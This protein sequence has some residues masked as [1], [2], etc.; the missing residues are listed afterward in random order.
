MKILR[1]TTIVLLS[2]IFHFS[3]SNDI[4]AQQQEGQ[5]QIR[6]DYS[7]KELQTFVDAN[8]EVAQ[9]QNAAEQEMISAIEEHKLDVKVFNEILMAKQNPNAEPEA[10]EEQLT[11]FDQA[12]GDVM[13]I[14]QKTENKMQKA[15]QDAG[16][17]VEE[18]QQIMMAYQQSPEV[19]QK[20]NEL[21]G[22]VNQGN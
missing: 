18:Y 11:K 5:Q 16:M 9:I 4:I 22:K 20:V 1:K 15:I 7:E 10:S 6:E 21:I 2:V 12:I 17:N 8:K 14:Q 3:L 19:Q 13:Q